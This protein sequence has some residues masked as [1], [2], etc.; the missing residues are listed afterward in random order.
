MM[1][2]L[3]SASMRC[4]SRASKRRNDRVALEQRLELRR[5]L[6]AIT[7]QKHPEILNRR[8]VARVVEIDNMQL[9]FR[10]EHVAGMKVAMQTNLADIAGP[11]VTR[12]DAIQHQFGN[13]LVGGR[14]CRPG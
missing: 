8:P 9:V 13:T 14:G 7:G 6:L 1:R 4:N 2:R 5:L 11:L 12:F 3:R 10:Y